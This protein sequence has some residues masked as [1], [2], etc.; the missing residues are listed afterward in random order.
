MKVAEVMFWSIALPGFGQILNGKLVKGIV[1]IGLEM[2][3][4]VQANIN[5]IIIY[6]FYGQI[7]LAI[8]TAEF[9][10][11]MFYPCL[12]FFAIWDAYK[13]AG[14]GN[15][16]FAFFPFVCCAYSVTIGTIFSSSFTLFDVLFG[17]I[18][19][20]ILSVLPGL[21]LGILL[22]MIMTKTTS[23]KLK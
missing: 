4:N 18:W 8:E 11:L 23:T 14:G 15:K 7:D 3:I 19:L 5:D 12:Y 16:P 21:F 17:P 10:W 20:P 13:D 9:Q 6:S 22:Q 1:L 2:I